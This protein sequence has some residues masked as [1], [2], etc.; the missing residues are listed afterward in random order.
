[1]PIV[2]RISNQQKP[3]LVT[4][5]LLGIAAIGVIIVGFFFFTIALV[6]GA[7][8]ALVIGVRLWWTVRKLKRGHS[9]ATANDRGPNSPLDGEYQVVERET[10]DERLTQP[11]PPQPPNNTPPAR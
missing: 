11:P 7:I 6:A 1:M 9:Q 5:V 4:R 3:G 8:L 10:A 2:Y